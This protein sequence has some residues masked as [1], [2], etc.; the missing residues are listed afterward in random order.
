V[1]GWIC[2]FVN[3]PEIAIKLPFWRAMGFWS[4]LMR[5]FGGS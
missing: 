1:A 2:L 4:P 3:D 5:P